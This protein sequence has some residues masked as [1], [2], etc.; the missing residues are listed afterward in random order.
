[1]IATRRHPEELVRR[2]IRVLA[3]VAELHK[4]GYQRV[5]VMPYEA[6]SGNH[7]RCEIAPTTVFYRNHGA[8]LWDPASCH[9]GGDMAPRESRGIAAKYTSGQASD[10]TYFGWSDAA[11]DDAR[12]LA[13][14]FVDRF[15]EIV[16]EGSGW[17]YPYAGWFQRVLGAA[18]RGYL[19]IVLWDAVEIPFDRVPLRDV[20]PASWIRDNPTVEH[21]LPLPA[22]GEL[23]QDFRGI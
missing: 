3:M 4:H 20:R 22:G 9:S 16:R 17:D 18:E 6:P 8:M 21:Y 2:S 1:M 12:A 15:P 7:W 11:K 23:E 13:Q 19:P 10:G 14:K 5:R